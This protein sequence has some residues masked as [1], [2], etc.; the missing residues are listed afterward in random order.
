MSTTSFIRSLSIQ[1][2]VIFALTMREM[3]TRYGRN[4]IGV[5]WLLVEPMLFTLAIMSISLFIKMREFSGMPIVAFA[6]TG[7]SCQL[8]WKHIA[9]RGKSA[10][11]SNAGLLYHRNVKN[12]DI[13]LARVLLEIVGGTA[14]FIILIVIFISFDFMSPP[15]DILSVIIAWSLLGWFGIGLALCVGSLSERSEAFQRVWSASSFPLFTLSGAVFMVD[16]IPEPA[17]TY[18][19]WVPMIHGTEMLRHG[20]FG[21]VIKTYEDPLYLITVNLCITFIGLMLVKS[22]SEGAHLK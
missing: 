5:L 15:K 4:N 9:N 3:L 10:I 20:F 11:G 1:R 7:Y 6:L 2:R 22:L 18:L 13:F 21:D 19:L 8:F 16:W 14:A 12:L 17:R